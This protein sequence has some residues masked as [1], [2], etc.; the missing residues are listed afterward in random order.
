MKENYRKYLDGNM[1]FD[2]IT[3]LGIFAL[4]IVLSGCFG[5]LYEFIFYFFNG[6]MKRFYWRGGNFLPWINIYATG[7]IMVFILTYKLRD[8]PFYVF[9]V[10]AISCGILEYFSLHIVKFSLF[11]FIS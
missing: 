8:R 2:R 11:L 7:A 4:V 9:L 1:N 5:W 6:G 3:L 10:S